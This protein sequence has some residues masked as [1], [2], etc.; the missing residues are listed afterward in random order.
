MES[1]LEI[2]LE[3]LIGTLAAYFAIMAVLAV[4]TEVA[5]DALK[6]RI[7]RKRP[8]PLETLRE[9]GDWIPAD[10]AGQMEARLKA[11]TQVL[12]DVDRTLESARKDWKPILDEAIHKGEA[13][14]K[15]TDLAEALMRLEARAQELNRYRVAA[16]RFLSL[17]VGIFLAALLQINTFELLQ[18]VIPGIF[19]GILVPGS[20]WFNVAG[21]LLSGLGASAG[22]SFW[23]DQMKRLQ[24][25][26]QVV[27]AA[28]ELKREAT[29]VIQG[30]LASAQEE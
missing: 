23:H 29:I 16:I 25:T 7:L 26:Q 10:K 22:S 11:I 3:A 17:V 20:P 6:I 24:Q 4:G 27:K 21:I 12:A 2:N 5:L 15:E 28:E 8:S 14:L 13:Y 1:L 30:A 18:P 9:V 19:S